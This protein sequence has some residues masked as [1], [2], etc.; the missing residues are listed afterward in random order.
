[1]P[2]Y[3]HREVL[4]IDSTDVKEFVIAG[5]PCEFKIRRD[6]LQSRLFLDYKVSDQHS[7]LLITYGQISFTSPTEGLR[8]LLLRESRFPPVVSGSFC[9]KTFS[10]TPT[11]STRRR[12]G[13]L[14]VYSVDLTLQAPEDKLSAADRLAARLLKA[15]A[16]AEALKKATAERHG[17][18]LME[19]ERELSRMRQ[20]QAA[21]LQQR[22]LSARYLAR[23]TSTPSPFD[24]CLDFPRLGRQLWA[25]E[26]TLRS[27]P[28]LAS[29]L[30]S[31][32]MEGASSTSEPLSS[33]K[34][35]VDPYTFDESDDEADAF[36]VDKGGVSSP[37]PTAPYK[38]IVV[39]DTSYTTYRAVLLWMQTGHIEFAPLHSSFRKDG[40][41]V[42]VAQAARLEALQQ[43]PFSSPSAAPSV[44]S[45]AQIP[46]AA[47]PK[48]VYR[49]ADLLS[50]DTLKSLALANYLSQLGPPSIAY[51]L[52]GDVATCY[53]PVRDAILEYV[54]E[55]WSEVCD[56][57]ATREMEDRAA[58]GELPAAAMGTAMLL[59]RR[60]AARKG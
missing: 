53:A 28:Y 33:T 14:Q 47:S 22:Q 9:S 2:Q 50:L 11:P 19:Q 45:T 26:S 60:L 25:V 54:V 36:F 30:T 8:T 32:F 42:A 13:A 44:P 43:P 1:M 58:A 17:R 27:S 51:E 46:L 57:P 49:L 3:K 5:V 59:A 31:D 4:S 56:A 52:Y 16:D 29:L 7:D 6:V 40:E 18:A 39:K 41:T 24:V 37:Q 10:Y 35:D 23:I 12:S 20:E 21:A 55:R 48:S 34:Q 38:R 15:G